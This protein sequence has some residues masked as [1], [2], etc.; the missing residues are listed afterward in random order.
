MISVIIMSYNTRDITLKCLEFLGLTAGVDMEVIVVDN[1]S[2][3]GSAEA[4]T[5]AYPQVKLIK[6]R[7]NLGFA[8]GNN[9]AMKEAKG[10]LILLLNSDCM[11][12][13]NT[14]A[15][16]QTVMDL[17]KCDMLGCLLLNADGT[18][19]QSWGYFPTL[20]RI[21]QMM[22]FID[23]LP[24]IRDVIDSIHVRSELRYTEQ[25]QVDWVTGAFVM[26]KREVFEKTGGFD[27]N[28]H[29]YGE[30]SEWMYRANKTGFSCTFSPNPRAVHLL[31]ASSTNRAPAIVGEMRG[32]LK[33]FRKHYSKWQ[34]A[35]LPWIIFAGCGL[36]MI[37]KP[38]SAQSYRQAFNEIRNE[39]FG[40]S[41]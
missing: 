32:W 12:F 30:E 2:T 36:R 15:K 14:L 37:L 23:N 38:D 34:Q 41:G 31:G 8:R 33:W 26:L 10:D 11:V 40:R 3:D 17:A 24:I 1:N 5:S 27:E 22:F 19:Q 4:I 21:A 28:Y 39:T 7:E 29:M 9:M 25:R 18:T 35:I 6:S 16:A 20:R 13:E